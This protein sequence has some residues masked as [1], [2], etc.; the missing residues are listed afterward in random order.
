MHFPNDYHCAV[1]D[2]IVLLKEAKE[3]TNNITEQTMFCQSYQGL[4]PK[5]PLPWQLVF[6]ALPDAHVTEAFLK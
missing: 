5:E 3:N 6:P 1:G 2:G 4:A